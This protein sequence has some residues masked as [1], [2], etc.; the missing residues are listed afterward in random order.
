MGKE[1]WAEKTLR[2]RM[3]MKRRL[4]LFGAAVALAASVFLAWRVAVP[5]I[6]EVFVDGRLNRAVSDIHG[7]I[8]AAGIQRRIAGDYIGI[9]IRMLGERGDI[10]W[11][12]TDG[13]GENAYGGDIRIAVDGGG[14]VITHVFGGNDRRI[15]RENGCGKED[16]GRVA[17]RFFGYGGVA[18][19]TCDGEVLRLVLE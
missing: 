9:S 18:D 2:G 19:I 4:A 17:L 6:G 11:R 10:P 7:V 15:G 8:V 12:F 13:V 16:C 1:A 14:A 3:V 5:W